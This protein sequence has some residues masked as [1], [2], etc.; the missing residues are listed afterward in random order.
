MGGEKK[1]R[2]LWNWH[3]AEELIYLVARG[4]ESSGQEKAD[5]GA[6]WSNNMRMFISTGLVVI[7]AIATAV[8]QNPPSDQ[9]NPAAQARIPSTLKYLNERI[10]EVAFEEAPLD[11][12]MDWMG[13][14]TPMQV[15][16]RWQTLEDAGIERDKPITMNVRGLRLSQVLWMIMKE[17]GGSDLNLAYRA[18]GRLLTIST[19]EDLGKEMVVRVYDV[20]DLLVRAQ[21]FTS[22]PQLDLQQAGQQSGSG[23][24]GQNIFGGN[25]GGSQQDDDNR[26][27]GR[28]GEDNAD[29]NELIDLIVQTVEPDSW[30]ANG[31]PG[32][33]QAFRNLLV[34]RNNILVH[35]SLGGYVR[36]TD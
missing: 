13:S 31:G 34:V 10:P 29:I 5:T 12:V 19:E 7:L 4:T 17:A 16:V 22:A 20:S 2:I 27:G 21:R 25:S 26:Q 9:T 6:T 3:F 15:V 14:L 28:N 8:A 35:Q 24:G 23:G 32:T 33:I 36:E 1:R 30:T 18:S 11:Q